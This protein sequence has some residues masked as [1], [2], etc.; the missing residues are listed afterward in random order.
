MWHVRT[1]KNLINLFSKSEDII[2]HH[3]FR[4]D[5]AS[6]A[7]AVTKSTLVNPND[8]VASCCKPFGQK[9]IP[10]HVV[11]VAVNQLNYALTLHCFRL[12]RWIPITL[13][14]ISALENSFDVVGHV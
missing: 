10:S 14:P 4:L 13:Q 11:S 9:A 6:L 2:S 5:E 1:T 8:I 7:L 12:N 3:L